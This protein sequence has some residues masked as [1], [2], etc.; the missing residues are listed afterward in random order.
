MPKIQIEVSYEP[1]LK[2]Y[3]D[4]E[5]ATD[6]M[7]FDA[8]AIEA[9]DADIGLLLDNDMKIVGVVDDEGNLHEL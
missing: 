8:R 2:F 9:G 6:A 1:N 5:N 7:L 4:C 3:P